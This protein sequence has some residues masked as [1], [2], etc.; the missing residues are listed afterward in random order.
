MKSII[1]SLIFILST[2]L[3]YSQGFSNVI[4]SVEGTV[5]NQVTKYPETCRLLVTD[6][7][8]KRVTAT[9]SMGHDGS[10]FLT[11]LKPGKSYII[12]LKKKNFMTEQIEIKVPKT[13]RYYE[14]SH[15]FLIKPKKVGKKIPISVPPFEKNKSTIRYGAD[16]FLNNWVNVLK[17]NPDFKFKIISFPDDMKDERKNSTYTNARTE[18][19]KKFLTDNGIDPSRITIEGN[20]K[21]DPDNPPPTE[22][23]AKG[24]RYIGTTYIEITGVTNTGM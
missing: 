23:R 11:G 12:T 4:V 1:L 18:S 10:Y 24:K 17:L 2:N 20:S 19:I 13:N 3:V 7:D 16:Y 22:R 14:L 21:T 5:Q 6:S 8:G 15:D 9:R